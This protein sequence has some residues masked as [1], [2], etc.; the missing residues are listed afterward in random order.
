MKTTMKLL[1][2][3]GLAMLV[4]VMMFFVSGCD[5]KTWI[6]EIDWGSHNGMNAGF[7]A[8][9]NSNHRLV[10]FSGSVAQANL[11]GGIPAQVDNHG[12]WRNP[13]VFDKNRTVIVI[14][15]MENDLRTHYENGTLSQ[16]N[17]SPYTSIMVFYNHG[18]LNE[19]RH[20]IT[21][22]AGGRHRLIVSNMTDHNVEL[23]INSPLGAGSRVLGFAREMTSSTVF[24]LTDHVSPDLETVIFPVFRFFH[25]VNQTV[26][27]IFPRWRSGYFEGQPYFRTLATAVGLPSVNTTFDIASIIKDFD[28][29]LGAVWIRIVNTSNTNIHFFQGNDAIPNS[30]DAFQIPNVMPNNHR[31]HVF[32]SRSGTNGPAVPLNVG[33]LGIGPLV[34]TRTTD[35][36]CINGTTDF[37]LQ[38]DHRYDVLVSGSIAGGFTAT[39]D[40]IG[41]EIKIQE[42]LKDRE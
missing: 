16:L 10:A 26:S 32:P 15:V 23:R 2:N 13:S 8:D 9:N 25:P 31:T 27:E 41:V 4:M 40:L 30:M 11:L 21:E 37:V 38:P 28:M 5:K 22:R 17:N 29:E 24:H 36:K 7:F 39:I 33:N 19:H 20:R 42:L 1:S 12:V 34:G 18:M 6:D 35:I 14:F 3:V